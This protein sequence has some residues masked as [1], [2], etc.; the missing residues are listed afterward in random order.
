[1]SSIH[2]SSVIDPSA[3]IGKDVY[4]GPFVVVGPDVTIGDGCRIESHA[5]LEYTTLG[6]RCR[7][8]PHVSI[9]LPP[10]HLRYKGEKTRVVVGSGSVFREGVTIHR[11]TA[12]DQ[13]LTSIGDD[14][15][16]MALSHVAHDCRIGNRVIMANAVQ[17]AGHITIEDNAF[18][19][20]LTAIHQFARIGTGALVSGGSMV[21]M[22]VAPYCIAQGDRAVLKGLNVVGMRRQGADRASIKLVKDAYQAVFQSSLTLNEALE[23]PALLVDNPLIKKF[24]D[25]L[26]APKRGF[27]R[28]RSK[29]EESPVQE[30]A[31]L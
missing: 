16:F 17:L 31:V 18:I 30:E 10:Q 22:D 13:S 24:R 20:G 2:P 28:P 11:G 1:M 4:I 29:N 14:C 6:P 21:I 7:V 26:S 23:H 3:Q 9:G 15:F 27:V 12:L 25:F 8:Y 5:V 19:S